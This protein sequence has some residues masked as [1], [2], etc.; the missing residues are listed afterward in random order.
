MAFEV[1]NSH[2]ALSGAGTDGLRF[3]HL[4]TIIRTQFGQD[5]FGTDIKAFW[6]RIV[7]QPSALPPKFWELFPVCVGMTWRRVITA[8]TMREWRLRIETLNLGA[9]QYGVGVSGGVEHVAL[10]TRIHHEAGKWVIQTGASNAFNSV[11]RK[12]MLDRSPCSS[13]WPLARQRLRG[14]SPSAIVRG[15]PQ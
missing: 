10:R 11:L 1:I 15:P 12:P 5:H 8:E 7:D 13:R 14:S 9:K 3:S 2:S 4:Q 6:R